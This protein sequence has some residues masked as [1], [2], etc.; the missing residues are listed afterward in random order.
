MRERQLYELDGPPQLGFVGTIWFIW[1]SSSHGKFLIKIVCY[2]KYYHLGVHGP[3]S[4][5]DMPV[6]T[7]LSKAKWVTNR[8]IQA[9]SSGVVGLCHTP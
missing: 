1:L 4:P 6:K 3:V 9:C 2:R 7:L 5:L 8:D